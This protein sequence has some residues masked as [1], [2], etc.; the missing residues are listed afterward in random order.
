MADPA[1]CGGALRGLTRR[2]LLMAV[3]EAGREDVQQR[4]RDRVVAPVLAMVYSELTPY[5]VAAGVIVGLMLVM[6]ALTLA[7]AASV[8]FR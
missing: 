1:R 6:T 4:L 8:R 3:D 2:V 7:L 5:L